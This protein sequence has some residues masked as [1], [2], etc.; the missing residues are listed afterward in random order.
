M[1]RAH[2]EGESR[3]RVYTTLPLGHEPE[4]YC[5]LLL[6]IVCG[7]EDDAAIAWPQD[8]MESLLENEEYHVVKRQLFGD[9]VDGDD[10]VV[11]AGGASDGEVRCAMHRTHRL[12][13]RRWFWKWRS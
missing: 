13:R 8:N 4:C 3:P 2:F 5:A 1:S 6:T 11:V 10:F 9:S 12:R 7:T